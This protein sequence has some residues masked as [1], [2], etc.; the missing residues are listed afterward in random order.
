MDVDEDPGQNSDLV[1]SDTLA[2]EFIRAFAHIHSAGIRS[3][4]AGRN[5]IIEVARCD[6][7]NRLSQ[8]N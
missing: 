3:R 1:S 4:V 5:L 7:L 2:L 6:F 8:V